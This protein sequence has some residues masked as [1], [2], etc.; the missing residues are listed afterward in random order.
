[1]CCFY[2]WLWGLRIPVCGLYHSAVSLVD[3]GQ[4]LVHVV[5]RKLTSRLSVST[6]NDLAQQ[7][8]IQDLGEVTAALSGLMGCLHADPESSMNQP[9]EYWATWLK[10]E[11]YKDSGLAAWLLGLPQT[12][13]SEIDADQ[14]QAFYSAG[15]A[16][17][18]TTGEFLEAL[19][20]HAPQFVEAAQAR[21]DALLEA[22]AQAK[23]MAGGQGLAPKF[24]YV[25]AGVAAV[26]LVDAWHKGKVAEA[27]TS[28]KKKLRE[29]WTSAESTVEE[30][31]TVAAHDVTRDRL[32]P[33]DAVR[34]AEAIAPKVLVAGL[35]VERLD[36]AT[37]PEIKAA[38]KTLALNDIEAMFPKSD[39]ILN[40]GWQDNFRAVIR[41]NPM[42][43]LQA[44]SDLMKKFS[45]S[46]FEQTN[47]AKRF[48]AITYDERIFNM[49]LQQLV[50]QGATIKKGVKN[51]IWADVK[52]IMQSQLQDSY[53]KVL[54]EEV[55][56]TV[57]N[58]EI[59]VELTA[60]EFENEIKAKALA[61]CAAV[62]REAVAR[63]NRDLQ[64][65]ME[66]SEKIG[67][68]FVDLEEQVATDFKDTMDVIIER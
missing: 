8:S 38:A 12:S 61:R 14:L 15:L 51:P 50:K 31:K 28:A 21:I 16:H 18:I 56:T 9:L 36:K 27:V 5:S 30:A 6:S 1:M 40:L 34:Q 7:Q 19:T 22:D 37:M 13:A 33:I 17:G 44:Y 46:S 26:L 2:S 55:K 60:E 24:G 57:R 63:F 32:H 11:G 64:L 25:A 52:E 53:E 4:A 3:S 68:E 54:L 29:L 67:G 58:D 23:R 35:D 62:R 45:G 42:V 48:A 66:A 41:D 65:A 59:Q 10:R 43:D 20:Q 39:L 47:L 49:S